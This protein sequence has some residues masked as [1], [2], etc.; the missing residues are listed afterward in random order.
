MF[1]RE[2]CTKAR[3]E[4]TAFSV[5]KDDRVAF[6][7]QVHGAKIFSSI[8]CSSI[9]NLSIELL[10]YQTTAV[11]FSTEYD[12]L[13]FANS[14][15]IYV[16]NTNNKELLQ[17]IHTNDGIIELI[18]F[19]PNSMYLVAGTK[20]GRVLQYRYDG[21]SQL[22]RICSFGH[23]SK[24]TGRLK[25]NYVSAFA[26]NDEYFAFSGFGGIITV[27]KMHSLA[28]KHSI[29]SSYVRINALCFLDG[30]RL[31]SGNVDGLIQIHSLINIDECKNIDTPFI[32]IKQ[33]LVMPNPKY[34]MVCAES[35]NLIII[36][37][38]TAK[39]VSRNYLSFESDVA[40]I[41][42]TL[43]NHL[44]V[45]LENNL[46]EKI[47][48]P[49]KELIKEHLVN[50]ELHKAYE[51]IE[52]D[53]ML[54]GTREYKRVEVLYDKLY[55]QA[56]TSLIN[57]NAKEARELLAMFNELESK[58]DDIKQ[59]FKAFEYYPRFKTLYLE[60]KYALAYAMSD[61]HP[62]LQHTMQYQKM[63]E[64]YN[65]NFSFAQ[66]QILRG[67][68]DVAKEILMPYTTVASKKDTIKIV[69]RYSSEYIALLK[70]IT[71][72]DFIEAEE[73]VKRNKQ[74]SKLP[75]YDSFKNATDNALIQVQELIHEGEIDLAIKHIK[76]LMKNP[77]LKEKLQALYREC[78]IV[79]KLEQTY[80]KK[81]FRECYE[82]MDRSVF[83]GNLE[84]S[85]Q[86][87]IHWAKLMNE[88]E[89][90][91]LKGDLK[92]IKKV[93]G[94][95]ILVKSRVNKIG[96]L[97]RVSFHTKIKFL[98]AKKSFGAA[99]SIIYSYID[100]FG[101]DR[102]ALVLMKTYEKASNKK[103]AITSTQIE[104]VPRNHWLS[105]PMIVEQEKI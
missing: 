79:R 1:E 22:S 103:L 27:L 94:D 6:S 85:E 92:S 37:T 75:M 48:L 61:K 14:N 66:K 82:I 62:V 90:H 59:M 2:N 19:V 26:S 52:N 57:G 7:T 95:L 80:E 72:K 104:R 54:E 29:E 101:T 13:A 40:R 11:A 30:Y 4:V 78:M 93:L 24:S 74:L 76:Q 39:V 41:A 43:D 105:S 63:E 91:A 10:G 23:G 86:L 38:H 60:K 34:I 47:Q 81:E 18:S 15:T 68:L 77:T 96:D 12:L 49:S 3:S 51:I 58:K 31:V 16:I 53:P 46:I 42:L 55:T 9:K 83:L 99:E 36:D 33:I 45:V 73:I 71:Q 88:C 64:V 8:S 65:E 5:L 44:L 21:R 56:I 28:N 67:R 97:I 25:N 70:A 35:K 17:T 100:I 32:N 84:L 87:E 102:E 89:E 20:Q 69:L 50:N 98:M